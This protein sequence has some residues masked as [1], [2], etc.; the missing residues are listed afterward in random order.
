MHEETAWFED[1]REETSHD[2][3]TEGVSK[4]HKPEPS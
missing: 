2:Y 1:L 4:Y 3:S